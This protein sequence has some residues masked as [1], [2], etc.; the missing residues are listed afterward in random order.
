MQTLYFLKTLGTSKIP[1][2]IQVRNADFVLIAH[3]TVKNTKRGL[4]KLTEYSFPDKF[5]EKVQAIEEGKL[6]KMEF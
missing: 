6:K 2:Y 5:E 3:F 4:D 1:D